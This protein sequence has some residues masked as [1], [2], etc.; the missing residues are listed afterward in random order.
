VIRVVV[1]GICGRMGSMVAR[2]VLGEDD[3]TLAG[4]V[5]VE[6]HES[7]GRTLCDVWGEPA[8]EIRV[9]RGLDEFGPRDL[10]VIVDF[11][12]PAQAVVCAEKAS[13]TGAGLVLGTTG[14]TDFQMAVVR[15]AA[16]RCPVVV[17]PNTSLGVS[18]LFA[19]AGQAREALGPG[20]DVEIVETHHRGKRDAPSGTASRLVEILSEPGGTPAGR[21][22]RFGRAGTDLSREADEIG[23]HSL[24]GGA[25]VGRHSVHFMSDVEEL[26][27]SHEA[28]SRE[29]FARGA[30][31]AVRFVHGRSPGVYDMIDVLGLGKRTPAT[32]GGD[33]R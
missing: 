8:S 15:K 32:G 31:R 30:I 29:A 18:V 22:V 20:F 3:M 9:R 4:G 27:L 1:S 14:L 6:T 17:A 19:L 13:A 23:V 25:V 33:E 10:D 2:N 28:F 11:S 26:T 7:I 5:E 21:V 12:V 16:E 24:R